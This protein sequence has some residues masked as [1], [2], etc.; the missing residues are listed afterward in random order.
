[1]EEEKKVLQTLDVEAY[2]LDDKKD[3]KKG[4]FVFLLCSVPDLYKDVEKAVNDDNRRKEACP[5]FS[6][7]FP[8]VNIDG[9]W[10]VR[11]F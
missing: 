4:V 7:G 10:A 3:M 5:G 11:W 9:N 6:S 2:Y 1:M 8:A